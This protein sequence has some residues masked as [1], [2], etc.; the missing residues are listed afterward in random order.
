MRILPEIN[1]KKKNL[2]YIAVLY[3]L[4]NFSSAPFQ[5]FHHQSINIDRSRLGIF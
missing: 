2:N 1:L 3:I 5:K 4:V